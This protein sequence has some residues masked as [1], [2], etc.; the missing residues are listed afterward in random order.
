MLATAAEFEEER[1]VSCLDELWQRRVIREQ[2]AEKYD[3]SHGKL[4]DM[5]Y[6][7][8][9]SGRRRLLH[10]RVAYALR[11]IHVNSPKEMRETI[12]RHLE[13]AGLPTEAQAYRQ[14]SSRRMSPQSVLPKQASPAYGPWYTGTAS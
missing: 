5:L 1:L 8:L 6:A 7:R 14:K 9:S 12:A 10:R 11:R 4:R 3:F 13:Q 2:G